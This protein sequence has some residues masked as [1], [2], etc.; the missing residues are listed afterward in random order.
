MAPEHL[1]AFGRLGSLSNLEEIIVRV[2]RPL[3]GGRPEQLRRFEIRPLLS[4]PATVEFRRCDQLAVP[5]PSVRKQQHDPVQPEL[6]V[7]WR[8]VR[9]G[10][11]LT[12]YPHDRLPV[13]IE[14]L[15]G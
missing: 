12:A 6:H 2:R 13:Q 4:D 15:P 3:N 8:R 7:L 10:W 1:A 9:I 14:P 5:W 11:K